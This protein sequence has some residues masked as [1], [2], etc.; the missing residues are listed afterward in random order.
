MFED[1]PG[2]LDQP[3]YMCDPDKASSCTKRYCKSKGLGPCEQ[4]TDVNSAKLDASGKPILGE[5]RRQ[6]RARITEE[7]NREW[8]ERGAD[9]PNPWET[10]A[11]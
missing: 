4:T 11:P 2:F 10:A 7:Q 8:R 1:D 6:W 3:V 9:Q 5:T